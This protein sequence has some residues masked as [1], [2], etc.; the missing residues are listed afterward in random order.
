MDLIFTERP[1]NESCVRDDK[2]YEVTFDYFRHSVLRNH[3]RKRIVAKS[4]D[5]SD[6]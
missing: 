6:F 5:R 4:P 3:L 1:E 2:K